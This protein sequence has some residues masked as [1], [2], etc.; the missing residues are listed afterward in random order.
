MGFLLLCTVLLLLG[1]AKRRVRPSRAF[2]RSLTAGLALACLLGSAVAA[3]TFAVATDRSGLAHLGQHAEGD[4]VLVN[5]L[6]TG[7]ARQARAGA[8][9][10]ER[11][12]IGAELLDLAVDGRM[13]RPG[14]RLLVAGGSD[15]KDMRAGQRVRA[16]GKLTAAAPGQAEAAVFSA[17]TRPLPPVDS[18]E[19]TADRHG[20]GRGHDDGDWAAAMRERYRKAA[21]AVGGD[22]AGL[23][24]GMVI[25]DTD[26]MDE[27]LL[28]AMRDTGTTHLTAV[29]GANCSLILGMLVMLARSFR[30]GR[31]TAAAA[32]LAGLAAFVWLVGPEPSVLRAAVMGA[33]GLMALSNGRPGRSLGFLCVAVS[34][35]LVIEPT[36]AGSAGF[37]LSVLATL[38]IVLLARPLM[39]GA[40]SWLPR[41]LSAA[42]AVPLSAQLFCAPV[43]VGIQPQFTT[44]SLPANVVMAPFVAPVTI[45]GT[46][47]VPVLPLHAGA[48]SLLIAPAAVCGGAIAAL[49]RFF[50]GLPGAVQ[51]WPEG[52]WGVFTMVMGS[53]V[54]LVLLWIAAHPLSCVDAVLRLHR[55]LE[56]WIDCVAAAARHR[57]GPGSG[58]PGRRGRLEPCTKTTGR[59]HS[60]LLLRPP[61]PRPRR[62]TRPA[63]GTSPR[64]P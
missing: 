7:D 17:R 1:G 49:A 54:T 40:P 26:G 42:V 35:L 29:S 59:K 11:W 39:D 61:R 10:T 44:F 25:G 53:A 52:P 55:Q 21:G 47:A 57:A 6:V 51:P 50:A 37:L 20:A 19:R 2:P 16:A 30:L 5:L 12:L 34:V 22:A 64:P 45:L 27:G 48:A 13:Y 56:L 9:G 31:A 3:H 32:A 58:L 38:G 23:L 62:R 41:P 4:S 15:W 33:I 36:L 18:P 60:W 63:G 24:P 28:A 14:T 43:L 8:G 46:L